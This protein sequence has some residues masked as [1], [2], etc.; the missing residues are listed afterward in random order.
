MLNDLSRIEM[1]ERTMLSS[2]YVM[3]LIFLVSLSVRW[4]HARLYAQ[5]F[6]Q[7]NETGTSVSPFLGVTGA[8]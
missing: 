2:L 8:I 4:Q 6:T 3:C 5:L 7:D 1:W